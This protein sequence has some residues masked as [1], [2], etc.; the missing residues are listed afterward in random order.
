MYKNNKLVA[1]LILMLCSTYAHSSLI[2]TDTA[3]TN[4]TGGAL[5]GGVFQSDTTCS[6]RRNNC[7]WGSEYSS[8]LLD[9]NQNT[10]YYNYNGIQGTA[11]FVSIFFERTDNVAFNLEAFRFATANDSIGRDPISFSFYGTNNDIIE[12]AN[13]SDLTFLMSDD[14]S[15]STVRRMEYERTLNAATSPHAFNNF[16]V[17]F[18]N[19]KGSQTDAQLSELRLLGSVQPA[20]VPEPSTIVIFAL[21]IMGLVSR[22]LK[23]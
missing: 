7:Y 11:G 12:G 19:L 21:G 14:F 4:I 6:V 23:K 15:Y 8:R 10:K 18:N 1:L 5:I 22:Q 20:S 2:F 16:L 3:N 13:L 9:G 17:V